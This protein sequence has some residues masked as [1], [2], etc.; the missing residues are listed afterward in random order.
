MIH[1]GEYQELLKHISNKNV[2][3]LKMMDGSIREFFNFGYNDWGIKRWSNIYDKVIGDTLENGNR[4]ITELLLNKEAAVVTERDW[5][6]FI[7]WE[8]IK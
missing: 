2:I 1:D 6:E 3:H 5:K 7:E 8:L 4:I